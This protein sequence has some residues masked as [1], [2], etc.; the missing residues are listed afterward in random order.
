MTGVA[1]DTGMASASRPNCTLASYARG[2]DRRRHQCVDVRGFWVDILSGPFY[3][4]GVATVHEMK[5]R[6]LRQYGG[7]YRHTAQDISEFNIMNIISEIEKLKPLDLGDE[8]PEE[9]E[10]P[11]PSPLE[12]LKSITEKHA[13]STEI[14]VEATNSLGEPSKPAGHNTAFRIPLQ[15]WDNVTIA[16]TI[17]DSAQAMRKNTMRCGFDVVYLG[18]MQTVKFL[19]IPEAKFTAD[20][21][22]MDKVLTAS[23]L[24]WSKA[25]TVICLETLKHVA[26]FSHAAKAKFQHKIRGCFPDSIWKPIVIGTGCANYDSSNEKRTQDMSDRVAFDEHEE[27]HSHLFFRNNN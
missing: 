16:F 24:P 23:A 14:S 5:S 6:L 13:A 22:W 2:H 20:D 15:G 12:Q 1:F 3:S 21:S 17:G 26:H 11:F 4:F 25:G 7:L 19:E 8:K 9:S 10:Y 18:Y 27:L